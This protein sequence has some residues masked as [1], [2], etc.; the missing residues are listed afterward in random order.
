MCF[1]SDIN[2]AEQRKYMCATQIKRFEIKN[3]AWKKEV[4]KVCNHL[5]KSH[6]VVL[7]GLNNS[8]YI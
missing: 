2:Q 7:C 8:Q 3:T 1:E 6:K 4:R 5:Y